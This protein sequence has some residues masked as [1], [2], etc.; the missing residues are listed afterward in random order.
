VIPADTD[1]IKKEYEI[2]INELTQ[3]NPELLDKR[4]VLAISKSDMLDD[5]LI[6]EM[7]FSLPADIPYVFISSVTGYG[8]SALK[9]LLW[10]ELNADDMVS[11]FSV[12]RDSIV[13]RKLDVVSLHFDEDEED[14]PDE[15]DD[16]YDE[17]EDDDDANYF[18]EDF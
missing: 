14:V 18:E 10:R 15:F 5:E 11:Q 16:L 6:H 3:Y 9:D 2:L 13:H 4:R 1:D 17:S 12:S 8:I 7:S